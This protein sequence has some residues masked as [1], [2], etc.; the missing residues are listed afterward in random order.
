MLDLLPQNTN[1][2]PELSVALC[3]AADIVRIGKSPRIVAPRYITVGWF[4]T[5]AHDFT[6]SEGVADFADA[7]DNT[8]GPV[9]RNEISRLDA[10]T[11]AH[12]FP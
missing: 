3:I 5:V 11:V 1:E 7:K 9:D 2:G 10:R 4:F 6:V 12:E 8:L